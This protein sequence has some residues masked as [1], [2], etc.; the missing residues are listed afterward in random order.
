MSSLTWSDKFTVED[1]LGFEDYQRALV[2]V[3]TSAE[4]PITI[5]IFGNWGSGKTS[6]M[7]MMQKDLDKA[8]AQTIWFDAWKYDKE[9]TLWRALLVQVLS[10]LRDALPPEEAQ[11]REQ[12]QKLHDSLYQSVDRDKLG[13]VEI[14]WSKFIQSGAK[15][16]AK[17]ALTLSLSF[18]PGASALQQI[19]DALMKNPDAE[20]DSLL[21]AIQREKVRLHEEQVKSLEQFQNGFATAVNSFLQ[22][23]T[24][25]FVAVFVD[26]LDRCLPEKAIE[27]L[28]AIKLFMDVSGCVFVL[29]VDRR[30]I[31]QGIETKYK[32]QDPTKLINGD[33]YLEKI[34]QV[35]FNLPP[36]ETKRVETFITGQVRDNFPP[37]VSKVF[38]VGLEPNPRKVKRTMNIFRLLWTL[39]EER[40]DL[41][42]KIVPELLAKMVVIQ[43]RFRDLYGD[44]VE[45]PSLLGDLETQFEGNTERR[46]GAPASRQATGAAL[47]LET[48][49][50][51]SVPAQ[52]TLVGKYVD[53]TALRDLLLTGE[54]RFR[55]TDARPYVFLATTATA[56]AESSTEIPVEQKLWDDLLSNDATKIKS[57]VA[58]IPAPSQ[59][60]YV[61]RLLNVLGNVVEYQAPQR[62]SAGNALSYLG[63]PREFEEM[64][65]VPAGDFLYGNEKKTET[66]AQPFRIGKYPVTN[67]QYRK[68]MEA[69][70]GKSKWTFLEG[71]ENHPVVNVS[72]E[73]ATAY[74]EWLSKTTKQPYRLPT[75]Q[76]WERAA[77]GTDGREYPWGSDFDA[78][79]ANTTEG[80][81]GDTSPVGAYPNGA[82]LTGTLDMSGN[83]WEWTA[84]NYDSSNKVL[85]GGS[86][87]SQ[88]GFARCAIR[89]WDRPVYRGDL[90]GFRVAQSV[91]P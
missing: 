61:N 67:A 60:N 25:K 64:V 5:G 36:L 32:G 89:L 30:V 59:T 83:V 40:H 62:V 76:E 46:T 68:F 73:D 85:R 15:G 37:S 65:E 53:R 45:Y 29:G 35:P 41:R 11:T 88:A 9:E 70:G 21:A 47:P 1:Q 3:V 42:G 10:T 19:S 22:A 7:R 16:V 2:R 31:E 74:C 28:E 23:R 56:D 38:A 43:V 91:L 79:K 8:H 20:A 84:S 39:S 77:R 75:E 13:A 27:V 44:V 69:A 80:G 86:F 90:V 18:I 6:L 87:S 71:R 58:A 24:L 57:A 17:G 63:D 55:D 34:I 66:L 33:D 82:S 81:I 78:D 12:L 51:A 54:K 49:A 50:P 48:D 52:T 26:D 14:D 72:W 4:T